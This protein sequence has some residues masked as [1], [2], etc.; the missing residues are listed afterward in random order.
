MTQC[1]AVG[2]F[3]ASIQHFIVYLQ[4]CDIQRVICAY[5]NHLFPYS[6]FSSI[7]YVAAIIQ[8]VQNMSFGQV[9]WSS[10][11]S[12]TR[13]ELEARRNMYIGLLLYFMNIHQ[14]HFTGLMRWIIPWRK[15]TKKMH[16][17]EYNEKNACILPKSNI[18]CNDLDSMHCNGKVIT[19]WPNSQRS[20]LHHSVCQWLTILVYAILTQSWPSAN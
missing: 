11:S 18:S 2:H 8:I 13:I 3:A 5:D 9:T 15:V 16:D 1:W 4:P 19:F 20:K 6:T 12:W 10:V 7:I 17:M 14:A